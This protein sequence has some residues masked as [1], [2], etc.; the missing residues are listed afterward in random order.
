ATPAPSP[1]TLSLPDAL[2]IFRIG[3]GVEVGL[4]RPPLLTRGLQ[5][6]DQILVGPV[7]PALAPPEM[8]W[9]APHVLSHWRLCSGR[10][11]YARGKGDRKSTRLN[12]S[13]VKISY[14]V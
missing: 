14:A 3:D 9:P 10:A 2:P 8:H 5:L 4:G 12:S 6:V 1:T 7:R 13:H 11:A